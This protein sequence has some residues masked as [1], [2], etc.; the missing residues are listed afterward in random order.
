MRQLADR[1]QGGVKKF[2]GGGGGGGKRNGGREIRLE[3]QKMSLCEL[4]HGSKKGLDKPAKLTSQKKGV[5][6][7]RPISNLAQTR[8]KG[9][10]TRERRGGRPARPSE[11]RAQIPLK[12][13]TREP[14]I[15]K[16][17]GKVGRGG[18]I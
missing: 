6:T 7:K 3:S 12:D 11:K 17:E 9:V 18:G 5:R 13:A 15:W 2:G 14:S 16:K 4:G 1:C 8:L 10:E